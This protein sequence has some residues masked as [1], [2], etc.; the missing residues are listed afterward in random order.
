MK[1][2]IERRFL[3]R[4]IPIVTEGYSLLEIE[5]INQYY[6]LVDGVWKRIRKIESNL[7]GE[8]YLHTIKTYKDGITY[9][10][11]KFL[12]FEEFKTLIDDIHGGKYETKYISKTRYKFPTGEDADFEGEIR[13]IK[14]EVDVFNFHLII[15]EIEIP[16]LKYEFEIPDFIKTQIICEVTNIQELSNRSLARPLPF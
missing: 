4:D 5:N 9:E 14:W 12:S 11:E 7:F 6:Y 3:L 15:A 16:D 8:Q 10:D 2:E 1:K 13:N